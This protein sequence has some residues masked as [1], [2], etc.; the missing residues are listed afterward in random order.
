[1]RPTLALVTLTLGAAVLLG[2]CST[3]PGL[4]ANRLTCTVAGD[5]AFVTSLYGPIGITAE[6]SKADAAEICKHAT[7]PKR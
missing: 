1:M 3:T 5:K 4:L 2:G 6:I 7:Q